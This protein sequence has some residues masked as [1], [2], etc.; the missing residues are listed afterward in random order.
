M[1]KLQ[2]LELPILNIEGKEVGTL[3]LNKEI[4]DGKVNVALLHQ[5]VVSY[6]ANKRA[7]TASTK[8]RGEVKGSGRKPWR[9]KGTGRA[10]I[11]S[12]RSPLWK[13]G[14]IVFGPKPRS[15]KK[16]LPQKMKIGALKSALNAKLKD[17]EI[18]ILDNLSLNLP[19]TKEFFKIIKNLKLTNLSLKF[20]VA[21]LNLNLGL[22]ARNIPKTE[23]LL[24]QNL[25]AYDAL[26]CKKIIFTKEALT[27]V[28]NRILKYL[29]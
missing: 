29:S 7:G 18:L 6:L 17:N 16:K 28:E 5:A 26:N 3:T 2:D 11:G 1:H 23:I 4:F 14:G 15:F 25:N 12:I 22:A 24:A 21:E 10:R 19:K 8:T 13:K 27:I 9:Q 20:I